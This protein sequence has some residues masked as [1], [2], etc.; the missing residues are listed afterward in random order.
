M[1]IWSE[2]MNFAKYVMG[3]IL[4]GLLLVNTL[5]YQSGRNSAILTKLN[6]DNQVAVSAMNNNAEICINDRRCKTIE[7]C[8]IAVGSIFTK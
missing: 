6:V 3:F 5:A 8:F 2:E 7:N 4:V 1:S